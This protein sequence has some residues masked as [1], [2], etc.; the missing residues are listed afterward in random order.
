MFRRSRS[1]GPLAGPFPGF[2]RV[3]ATAMGPWE[4]VQ[5]FVNNAPKSP[6][7]S[8]AFVALVRGYVGS[9]TSSPGVYRLFRRGRNTEFP[10]AA[11]GRLKR[12]LV[13]ETQRRGFLTVARSMLQMYIARALVCYGV[14]MVK[15]LK[16]VVGDPFIGQGAS[17]P[18]EELRGCT[19]W[20][21]CVNKV[22]CQFG[23]GNW[24]RRFVPAIRGIAQVACRVLDWSNPALV[25]M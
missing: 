13:G 17:L 20:F 16:E 18:S 6:S 11:L 3:Y 8:K 2:E 21:H 7:A 12:L 23:F 10:A 14:N 9:G 19:Q 4:A 5:Q 25:W 24:K 22:K 15:Y 1:A